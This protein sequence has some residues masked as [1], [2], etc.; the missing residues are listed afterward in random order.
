MVFQVSNLGGDNDRAQ[1]KLAVSQDCVPRS[2][3]PRTLAACCSLTFAW[4]VIRSLLRLLLS[5]ATSGPCRRTSLPRGAR[6]WSLS[7]IVLLQPQPA[8]LCMYYCRCDNTSSRLSESLTA[9]ARTLSRGASVT[10]CD[11]EQRKARSLLMD[12]TCYE[13][14]A[15]ALYK[16]ERYCSPSNNRRLSLLSPSPTNTTDIP[17]TNS[18]HIEMKMKK[19]T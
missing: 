12:L 10:H 8:F 11:F 18:N 4:R 17:V 5:S 14:V 16:A 3:S 19:P 15:S 6:D 13:S 1:I 9:P 2:A 7:C